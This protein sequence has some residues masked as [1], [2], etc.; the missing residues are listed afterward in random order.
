MGL[1]TYDIL[2]IVT[3][4][5]FWTMI[6]TTIA[7]IAVC[8]PAVRRIVLSSALGRSLGFGSVSRLYRSMKSS[9]NSTN[10]SD[11]EKSAGSGRSWRSKESPHVTVDT[12]KSMHVQTQIDRIAE[13]GNYGQ[14]S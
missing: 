10:G 1:P 13:E 4:E 12:F 7:L 11:L 5:V 6:E 2:G 9:K 8:L 3:G 14:R